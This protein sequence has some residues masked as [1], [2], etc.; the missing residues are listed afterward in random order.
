MVAAV[1]GHL[2]PSK[3]GDAGNIVPVCPSCNKW[4]QARDAA[5]DFGPRTLVPR[6]IMLT[7]AERRRIEG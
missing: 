6:P 5:F 2:D 4:A 1:V 7:T 3:E